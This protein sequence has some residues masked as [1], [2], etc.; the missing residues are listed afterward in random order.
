M[1]KKYIYSFRHGVSMQEVADSLFL[2]A[3][4]TESVFGRSLFRLEAS[5]RL[6][7][8]RRSCSIDGSTSIGRTLACIFHGFI[9]RQIGER[10]FRIHRAP[11]EGGM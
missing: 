4:A 8:D 6:E 5:F 9:S 1:K 10:R 3:L 11:S 2:A 7:T